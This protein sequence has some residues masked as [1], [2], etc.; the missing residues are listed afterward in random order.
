M[1]GSRPAR[2]IVPPSS[3]AVGATHFLRIQA[4][5]VAP[6]GGG[7]GS[8]SNLRA[9]SNA[10]VGSRFFCFVFVLWWLLSS[11]RPFYAVSGAPLPADLRRRVLDVLQEPALPLLRCLAS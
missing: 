11:L 1:D 4:E 6:A 2:V 5:K 7:G 3:E 9:Q 10:V 8:S